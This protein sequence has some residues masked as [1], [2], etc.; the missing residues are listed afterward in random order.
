MFVVFRYCPLCKNDA[1]QVVMAGQKLKHSKKKAK[2]ASSINGSTRDWGKVSIIQSCSVT[3]D[4]RNN[5][6]QFLYSAF[7]TRRASQSASNIITP[8]HWALNHSLNHL[9]SLGSIQPV[10][11]ICATRLNQSQEPS[12]PSQVP[13][14][15]WVE[16]SNYS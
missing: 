1:S 16:R 5:N 7:H 2:M 15:P 9:S 3:Q 8:G 6:N 14:Y 10:R 11:Q 4:V 13:I 12:L